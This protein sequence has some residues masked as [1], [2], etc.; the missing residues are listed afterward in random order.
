MTATA[1]MADR[2]TSIMAIF[3]HLAVF[4]FSAAALS[5]AEASPGRTVSGG[6]TSGGRAAHSGGGAVCSCARVNSLFFSSM[7]YFMCTSI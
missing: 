2:P 6:R 1:V 3:F 4:F 7:A 5:A